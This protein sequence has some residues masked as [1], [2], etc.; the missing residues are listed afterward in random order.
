MEK[1]I[2]LAGGCFWGMQAF[3]KQLAGVNKTEVGY[4]N[5]NCINP[6]YELVC[7]DTSG[8]AETLCV[9]YENK[10]IS[11]E[12]LLAWFFSVIDPCSINHQGED[13]GS[14]YRSGVY[15]IDKEDE[16]IIRNYI[17]SISTQYDKPIM[18]EV[19]PL[20]NFYPAE[21]YHQDYLIKNPSG[22]CHINMKLLNQD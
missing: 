9:V 17:S 1:T 20:E 16:D 7:S 12:K 13:S 21:E 18:T 10:T 19:L 22:Y 15:F 6:S 5:G 2:Y 14:Q 4:A 3:F 8:F 11:L